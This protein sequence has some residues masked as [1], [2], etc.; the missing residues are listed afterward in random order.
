MNLE[1]QRKV[2]R[3]A[4]TF[5]CR[6][7]SMFPNARRQPPADLKPQKILVILLSEMGSLVLAQPMF[8][9]IKAKYPAASLYVSSSN[10]TRKSWTF[11]GSSLKITS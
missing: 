6:V 7:L 9:R 2:D 5:F 4:G 10:R 1:F 3:I 8:A 11:C